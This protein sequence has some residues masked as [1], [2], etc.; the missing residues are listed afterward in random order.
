MPQGRAVATIPLGAL[1]KANATVLGD[2]LEVRPRGGSEG[3]RRSACFGPGACCLWCPA[4]WSNAVNKGSGQNATAARSRRCVQVKATWVG[5]TGEP[6]F[7]KSTVRWGQGAH[8]KVGAI[9]LVWRCF[10]NLNT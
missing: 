2:Q 3:A 4:G 5:P 6:Y 10:A 9:I 1:P 8:E 7:S